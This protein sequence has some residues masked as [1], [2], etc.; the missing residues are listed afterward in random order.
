MLKNASKAKFQIRIS[1]KPLR[2]PKNAL[3]K[4][5]FGILSS[6]QSF[7]FQAPTVKTTK[8]TNIHFWTILAQIGSF[9]HL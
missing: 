8:V 1:Q 5:F 4:K 2:F 3:T 9:Y 6:L 7:L